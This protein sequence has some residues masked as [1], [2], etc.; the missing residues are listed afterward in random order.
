[1]TALQLLIDCLYLIVLNVQA[2]KCSRPKC[3]F[4]HL[5]GGDKKRN[6]IDCYWES[7][8]GGCSKPHCPFLHDKPKDPVRV[9][10]YMFL[11]NLDVYII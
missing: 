10:T 5:D 6:V 8:P 7:Q 4:R 2:G 9:Y 11:T 3:I 1:M